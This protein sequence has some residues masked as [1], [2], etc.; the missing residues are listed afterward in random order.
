MDEEAMKKQVRADAKE[1]EMASD[2]ACSRR[3]TA[4]GTGLP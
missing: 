4:A 2:R 1:M 3:T